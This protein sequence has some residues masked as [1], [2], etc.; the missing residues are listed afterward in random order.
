VTPLRIEKNRA[1]LVQRKLK[2]RLEILRS[3]RAT[4]TTT[5][6]GLALQLQHASAPVASLESQVRI[7]RELLDDI[8]NDKTLLEGEISQEVGI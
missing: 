3:Q 7:L 4:N 2:R 8:R 6:E 5:I 1:V